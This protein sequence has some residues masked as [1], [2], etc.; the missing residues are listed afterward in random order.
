M[1]SINYTVKVNIARKR[2]T[3]K[4]FVSGVNKQTNLFVSNEKK[5]LATNTLRTVVNKKLIP[6]YL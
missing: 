5:K 4:V 1:N 3:I 6:L 2:K